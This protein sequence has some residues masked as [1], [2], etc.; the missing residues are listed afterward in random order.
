ME[1]NCFITELTALMS[2]I[3][4]DVKKMDAIVGDLRKICMGNHWE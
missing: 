2:L 4:N 1:N 3:R